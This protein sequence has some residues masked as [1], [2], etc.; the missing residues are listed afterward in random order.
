MKYYSEHNSRMTAIR[1]LI[2]ASVILL[3]SLLF[4][5]LHT[6]AD[7]TYSADRMSGLYSGAWVQTAYG[8]TYY[9]PVTGFADMRG[10]KDAVISDAVYYRYN[11]AMG[12]YVLI[13]RGFQDYEPTLEGIRNYVSEYG[14]TDIQAVNCN[15]LSAIQ[16]EY[17]RDNTK[18]FSIAFPDR[19]GAI[20]QV[21]V[22]CPNDELR[23]SFGYEVFSSVLPDAEA[24][25]Y[26]SRADEESYGHVYRLSDYGSI[27]N[28]SWNTLLDFFRLCVPSDSGWLDLTGTQAA[29]SSDAIAMYRND[30]LGILIVIYYGF[31]PYRTTEGIFS[32]L[33]GNAEYLNLHYALCNNLKV[34]GFEKENRDQSIAFA[35]QNGGIVQVTI[36]CA[37]PSLRQMYAEQLFSSLSPVAPQDSDGSRIS[38]EYMTFLSQQ[39][40][41]VKEEEIPLEGS[42][43]AFMD[44]NSDGISELL[45]RY[46]ADGTRDGLGDIYIF[47]LID[48]KVSCAGILKCS[49]MTESGGGTSKGYYYEL[50]HDHAGTFME[51]KV[52]QLTGAMLKAAVTLRIENDPNTKTLTAFYVNGKKVDPDQFNKVFILYLDGT[53]SS[54]SD[55]YEMWNGYAAVSFTD[56]IY[57]GTIG[58]M[59]SSDSS[60]STGSL[61]ESE[62]EVFANYLSDDIWLFDTRPDSIDYEGSG[63]TDHYSFALVDVTGDGHEEL[64]VSRAG[65]VYPNDTYFYRADGED[66]VLIGGVLSGHGGFTNSYTSVGYSS[67]LHKA[68]SCYY[69]KHNSLFSISVFDFDGTQFDEE[70]WGSAEDLSSNRALNGTE[71]C[72]LQILF[73]GDSFMY[74]LNDEEVSIEQFMNAFREWF[75]DALPYIKESDGEDAWNDRIG[76]DGFEPI[77]VAANTPENRLK[78]LGYAGSPRIYD[79]PDDPYDY[80]DSDTS[81]ADS[82]DDWDAVYEAGLTAGEPVTVPGDL[83]TDGQERYKE[84][85]YILPQSASQYLTEEDIAHLTMKGCCYARNEIYARHGRL[86]SASELQ[87]YFDDRD[88]YEGYIDPDDFDEEYTKSVFNEYEYANAYFLLT[89]E[90]E[91]GMYWPE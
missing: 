1:V 78:I 22:Q 75:G 90:Q 4:F 86:F 55:S 57:A 12:L 89:Y 3:L 9:E 45:M 11:K 81:S 64:A 37:D 74:R 66:I 5:P 69:E 63:G 26:L 25:S 42:Q 24:D 38:Q 31:Q 14:C 17:Q 44:V 7:M 79:S 91:H 54:G 19:D 40:A 56:N 49:G 10:T 16:F 68:Y 41:V 8:F 71:L 27:Y 36:E 73:M 2:L 30:S 61:T 76:W 50:H 39:Y 47:V 82:S 6:L 23:H 52:Y 80:E 72:N 21:T 32:A 53:V 35:D 83:Y 67:S 33:E 18:E 13:Y 28:G 85:G 58:Q 51:W 84:T 34:V 15:G 46:P 20:M 65:D 70:Y 60:G 88:W 77:P 59:P 48:G 43:Y 87:T 62:K 29:I